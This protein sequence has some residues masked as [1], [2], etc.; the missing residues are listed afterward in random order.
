M[1][2]PEMRDGGREWRGEHREKA[3]I[4]LERKV[5]RFM[6]WPEVGDWMEIQ[7]S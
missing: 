4:H 5:Y 1:S 6:W 3:S 2:P 7:A